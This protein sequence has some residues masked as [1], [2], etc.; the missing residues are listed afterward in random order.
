MHVLTNGGAQALL[1]AADGSVAAEG[2]WEP[3]GSAPVVASWPLDA[4]VRGL[5][6]GSPGFWYGFHLLFFKLSYYSVFQ[7]SMTSWWYLVPNQT[8]YSMGNCSG[9]V[10]MCLSA[11]AFHLETGLPKDRLC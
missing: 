8:A 2:L 9:S 11:S 10:C 7:I 1:A 5:V 3:R 4:S 6:I